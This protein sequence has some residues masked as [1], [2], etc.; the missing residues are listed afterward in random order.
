MIWGQKVPKQNNQ[1]ECLVGGFGTPYIGWAGCPGHVWGRGFANRPLN[2][3]FLR[4]TDR[5]RP[6]VPDP[7]HLLGRLPNR[8]SGSAAPRLPHRCP[9]PNIG[10]LSDAHRS[11]LAM[12]RAGSPTSQ[13]ALER[14]WQ[15]Q[16]TD[17]GQ[18]DHKQ[19]KKNHAQT[20]GPRHKS[21][22]S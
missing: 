6:R 21:K 19:T 13:S 16:R 20:H 10:D 15:R 12:R 7:A 3:K 11:A 14:Q 5:P 18:G 8:C 2:P 9:T 1:L 17:H 4:S 22:E